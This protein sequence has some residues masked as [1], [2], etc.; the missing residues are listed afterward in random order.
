MKN[1]NEIQT[2]YHVARLGTV[3]AAAHTLGVHRATVI[4]HIDT[5]EAEL[6]EK[7][8]QR[9]TKGYMPTELGLDLMR[10]ARATEDQFNQLM[11]KVKCHEKDLSGDFV[12]TS[13]DVAASILLPLLKAFQKRYEKLVIH[14]ISSE[15]L[16][17][18]EYGEAHIAFRF[19]PKPDHPDHV[20]QFFDKFRLGLYASQDYVSE[21]GFPKTPEDYHHHFFL[22]FRDKHGHIPLYK[23][24]T[25]HVPKERIVFRGT[26][27]EIINQA[28]INGVGIGFFPIHLAEQRSDLVQ[29]LEPEPDWEAPIWLITHVD[30]HRSAKVQKFTQFIKQQGY[31]NTSG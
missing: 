16:L 11:G 26:S 8:F 21:Y 12:V 4:R 13:L 31:L 5:L 14:F 6:G 10:V 3:S 2:A 22:S 28:V 30:L 18:L 20:V 29:I 23:W 27:P 1:W 17:R 24:I 25:K 9:H 7:I 19:G 15:K